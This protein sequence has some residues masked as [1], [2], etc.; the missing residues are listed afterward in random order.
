MNNQTISRIIGLAVSVAVVVGVVAVGNFAFSVQTANAATVSATENETQLAAFRDLNTAVTSQM[1]K[2]TV[3]ESAAQGVLDVSN[4]QVLDQTARNTLLATINSAKGQLNAAADFLSKSNA[5]IKANDTN[6]LAS[7]TDLVSVNMVTNLGMIPKSFVSPTSN[8]TAAITAF[9][10][11]QTQAAAAAASAAKAAAEVKA[12]TAQKA[13]TYTAAS[14]VTST[15]ANQLTSTGYTINVWTDTGFQASIDA[16]RG[17]VDVTAQYNVHTIAEHWTCGGSSFPRTAGS[18]VT[19]TG[20]DA[21]TYRVDGVVAILNVYKNKTS[22]I[23]RGYD[24]IYQS[25]LNNNATTEF[26]AGMTKIG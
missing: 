9:K 25:C 13:A 26:F 2:A 3:A 17:G 16:C 19:L 22:D 14:A 21:G 15:A 18:I 20:I 10:I 1:E 6:M 8:V 7:L 11:K 4:G 24:L 5:A 12:A 23:P